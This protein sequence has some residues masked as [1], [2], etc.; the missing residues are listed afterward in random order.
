MCANECANK[1]LCLDMWV[2]MSI[3]YVCVK[4]R[5]KPWMSFLRLFIKQGLSLAW[6]SSHRLGGLASEFQ[7]SSPQHCD[8]SPCWVYLTQ[9]LGIELRSSCLHSKQFT[10]WS[11]S[12]VPRCNWGLWTGREFLQVLSRQK[13]PLCVYCPW[14]FD[15][16]STGIQL[17]KKLG[18]YLINCKDE[19]LR[20]RASCIP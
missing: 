14:L 9:I 16:N 2:H 7:G 4:A 15:T 13:S 11:S 3:V 10:K 5:D 8:A 20:W 17:G 18:Q 6:S 1:L 19:C 12:L